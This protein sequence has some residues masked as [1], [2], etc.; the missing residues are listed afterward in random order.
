MWIAT[1]YGISRFT[2]AT[3]QIENYFFSSYTLGNV[4]SENTACVS[5][6]GKLLF[7]TNYGL[8]VLNA[9]K[10][11]NLDKTTS[12]VFT[13]LQINGANMLPGVEDS[14]LQEAMP[15]I[16]ELNLKYYQQS[17]VISFSTFNYLNG[18]SKYSYCM[19]PYDTGMEFA[20]Q[21]EHRH[22]PELASRQVQ[23]PRESLQRRR[24]LGRRE[25]DG[26]CDSPS[27]LENDLG[28][29]VICPVNRSSR[30]FQFPYH[31]EF[32]RIA[33]PHRSRKPV[34]GIQTGILH[35]YIS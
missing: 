14:P 2:P 29:P 1:E 19:P 34:D 6:D 11:E 31:P 28:L 7:G 21:P 8:V 35:Q 30:L 26:D 9:D 13:G 25:C 22:L 12:V 27:V 3:K 20:F 16:N 10:I 24:Y 4:Y 32:Q 23:T 5:N 18:V 15:Y 17:F 33:Q